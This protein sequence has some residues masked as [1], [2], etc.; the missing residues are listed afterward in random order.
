MRRHSRTFWCAAACSRKSKDLTQRSQRNCG[1]KSEK[2]R[3]VYRRDA[4][5]TEKSGRDPSAG[6]KQRRRPQDD[7]ARRIVRDAEDAGKGE[8]KRAGETLALHLQR[9]EEQK[10]RRRP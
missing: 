5:F 7:D 1:E 2:D 6:L 8:G 10:I 3:G 9:I 4:E